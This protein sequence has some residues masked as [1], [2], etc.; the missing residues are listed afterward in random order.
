MMIGTMALVLAAVT[1]VTPR[2]T[3]EYDGKPVDSAAVKP[4][5][6]VAEGE[7]TC[8]EYRF[9]KGLKVTLRSRRFGE[10]VEWVN[11]FENDGKEDT[12]RITRLRDAD[13]LI[14]FAPDPALLSPAYRPEGLMTRIYSQLGST[15]EEGEFNADIR[16]MTAPLEEEDRRHYATSGGRSCEATMPFFNAN[17]GDEGVI[18]AIGWTGQWTCDVARRQ[19]GAVHVQAGLEDCDFFLRPGERFRTVS[20][21]TLPYRNGRIGGQNAFRR[22]VRSHYSLIGAPGRPAHVPL[23]LNLWGGLTTAQM[24]ERVEFAAKKN[25]GLELVW[26]D[27]GWYAPSKPSPS[28]FCPVWYQRGDWRPSPEVHPGLLKDFSAAVKKA[29]M[30]FLLWFEPEQANKGSPVREAHPDWFPDGDLIDLGN[31]A[32]WRWMHD[33]VAEQIRALGLGCYRQDFNMSPLGSWRKRDAADGRRG[34]HEILHVNGLYAFWDA[35]LAEFP[36]LVIDNCASGGRRIDIE[37]LRRSVPLW[38]SDFQCPANHDPDVAQNHLL[39]IAQWLPHSG[40]SVGRIMNDVYRARSCYSPAMGNNFLFSAENGGTERVTDETCDFVRRMTAEAKRVRA[41]M[42]GDFYPLVS[43]TPFADKSH[44]CAYSFDRPEEG[45]GCVLAFR[46]AQSPMREGEFPLFW[47]DASADYVFTDAD[48]G[49]EMVQPG[50][51]LAKR[52]L[53]IAL[54]APRSSKLL[55][56]RRR[57]R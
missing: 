45:T 5:R 2:F 41:L 54:D 31:P 30:K 32:A 25:L 7:W 43:M 29:G 40:T 38:R 44:W 9:G 52:G 28:E 57:T 55:F 22:L 53:R 27:A 21:V 42:D 35:L 8:A 51:D 36:H 4:A 20:M 26:V 3:F 1:P 13:F 48:T 49:T 10:A 16:S 24:T 39:G 33:T 47:L 15:W 6:T 14:P 37:T 50:A 11:W 23:S 18:F 56:Y 19:G 46:R 12:G 34:I 17:R